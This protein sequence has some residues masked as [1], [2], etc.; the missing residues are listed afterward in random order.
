[1]NSKHLGQE[2]NS[3]VVAHGRQK[4]DDKKGE[5]ETAEKSESWQNTDQRVYT[6]KNDHK[7]VVGK[8]EKDFEA[9]LKK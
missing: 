6:D 8:L 4:H 1:M 5:F 2:P 9:G 3:S 7:G